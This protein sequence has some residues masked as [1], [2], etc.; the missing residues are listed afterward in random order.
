MNNGDADRINAFNYELKRRLL[1]EFP[2][3]L[4]TA[5]IDTCKDFDIDLE[6]A[7]ELIGDNYK[8]K[9]AFEYH[10]D[11]DETLCAGLF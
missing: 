3:S 9:L 7:V 4:L 10:I 1:F 11:E 8:E 5:I 6:D 2:D